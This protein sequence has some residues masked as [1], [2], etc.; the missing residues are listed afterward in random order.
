[1]AEEVK[2]WWE[3]LLRNFEL[4]RGAKWAV[5]QLLGQGNSAV[6][7]AID[8]PRG[9]AA[10]KIYK[11]EFLSGT[12]EAAERARLAL[13]ERLQGHDCESLVKILEVGDLSGSAYVLMEYV[14]WPSLDTMLGAIKH[15]AIPTIISD[16]ANAAVW[17][18]KNGLVHR[19][20]KPANI[21]VAPDLSAAKLVDLGVIRDTDDGA[22]DLTDQGKRRPFVATAQ[23]SSPEY[24]FRLIEPSERLWKA[25]SIY[26]V[27]AVLHD[28]LL[29]KPLFQE[30]VLSENRYV[31]AMAV[32]KK[33][34][35]IRV[36]ACPAHW[37]A[38][39][40]RALSKDMDAR[41]ASVDWADFTSLGR[42]DFDLARRQLGLG[43]TQD[44]GI[45]ASIDSQRARE[46]LLI[47]Q[48][49]AGL[50]DVLDQ[51]LR[52]EGYT[53]I[54]WI[55]DDEHSVWIR[56]SVPDYQ[57]K[58]L[59]IRMRLEVQDSAI[60]LREGSVLTMS[61]AGVGCDAQRL[62]WAG[63]L[64]SFSSDVSAEVVPLISETMLKR[65]YEAHN[66]ATLG[67]DVHSPKVLGGNE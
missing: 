61:A 8:T 60:R 18:E 54:R 65:L 9:P 56:I 55:D 40:K 25:L 5:R 43:V 7:F 39:A 33:T 42:F 41:L 21:L 11:P 49:A 31:L 15:D 36:G 59:E 29:G 12:N 23:Y 62:L 24:L 6:V 38:L 47:K 51:K 52:S 44:V 2:E 46:R 50:R 19:D 4:E 14:P 67:A 34:P 3:D 26:Q 37:G 1:M 48:L 53:R 28:L 45:I 27:G 35:Q 10:L 32:Y 58:T 63:N 22:P 30:E 20:I 13:H 16:V 57:D 17:L 64:E 66:L